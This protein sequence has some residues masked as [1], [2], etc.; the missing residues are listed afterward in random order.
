MI[1][2]KIICKNW[3]NLG[4]DKMLISSSI[5][6]VWNE[7]TFTGYT[8]KEAIKLFK[9]YTKEVSI[10]NKNCFISNRTRI[11]KIS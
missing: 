5:N 11:W 1:D 7:V 10:N 4:K 9:E 3:N 8:K 6:D 2:V